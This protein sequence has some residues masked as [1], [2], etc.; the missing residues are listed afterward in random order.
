MKTIDE[1]FGEMLSCLEEQT[2]LE[3]EPGC[4]LSVRMYAVA[5]QVYALYIQAQWVTRQAFPQTAESDYLDLHGQLRGLTRKQATQALAPSVLLPRAL[6]LPALS[7][8]VPCV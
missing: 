3:P 1:I 2:G 4:D 6:T 5:A 7:H 8:K